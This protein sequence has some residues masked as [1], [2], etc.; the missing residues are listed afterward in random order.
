MFAD[1]RQNNGN[2][3]DAFMIKHE[4]GEMVLI[5]ALDWETLN[6]Y[7]LTVQV[8]DG[9]HIVKTQYLNKVIVNVV[10][11]NNHRPEFS[12]STYVV[13]VSENIPIKTELLELKASDR[14]E[15][16]TLLY[17]I[18]SSINPTSGS[19]FHLD[20]VRGILS[21][22]EK[23]DREACHQHV[24][25]VTVKDDGIPTKR[26][27]FARVV[28]NV[29]DHNDHAPR[30]LADNF[31]GHVYETA[32]QGS[33][34]VQVMAVDADKGK[35][36]EIT[37][38]IIS[39]N[40]GGTFS[41]HE[42]LGTIAVVKPL[43]LKSFSEYE[44]AL[45]V[46]AT[47][48]GDPP[49]SSTVPVHVVVT[50][51]DNAPPKIFDDAVVG[52]VCRFDKR[53]Y[54]TEIYENG[55]VGSFVINVHALSRSTVY[56]EMIDGNEMHRLQLNPNS[57]VVT[58]A[59]TIDYELINFLNLTLR[60]TN[61]VHQ[62]AIATLLVHILDANDNA[63][64]FQYTTYTGNV[65]EAAVAATLVMVNNTRPLAVFAR[66]ADSELNALLV[67]EIVDKI[68]NSYFSIDPNTGAIRTVKTLDYEERREFEFE[69]QVSDMGKP[70]LTA[71][72]PA[73]V[74]VYVN[75]VN[76]CSPVFE[77][78]QY[79]ASIL[80]PTFKNVVVTTVRATDADEGS[81]LTYDITGGNSANKFSIDETTGVVTVRD[82]E[83]LS[84]RYAL[85]VRASDGKMFGW[86]R[87]SIAVDKAI[88]SGLIFALDKYVVNITE[89]RAEVEAVAV[90]TVLGN[91]LD[92]HLQFEILNPGP[93]FTIG[94]TSGVIWTK[95]L[96][97]D[98]EVHDSY[99]LIVEARSEL[100]QYRVAQVAVQVNVMDE[101]D[102][103]PLF[104]NLPYFAVV[105]LDARENDVILKVQA[106]DKD[107]GDNGEVRYELTEGDK[108]LFRVNS[109]TGDLALRKQLHE[110]NHELQL[111]VT[112]YDRGM[113]PRHTDVTVIVRVI[114]RSMPLFNQQ[115]YTSAVPE[116]I[117]PYSPV[118]SVQAN[119]PE[120]RKLI[121]SIVEGNSREEFAV[122]F[123]TEF[124]RSVIY[125]VDQLDY[126]VRQSYKLKLQATDAVSGAHAQVL[127]SITVE[128]VNDNAP[129]FSQTSYSVNVLETA[130]PST[131]ILQLA[132][133]DMDSGVNKLVQYTLLTER[134]NASEYFHI[135]PSEAVISIKSPLDREQ[136]S[137]HHFIVVA[138]DSGLP[139]LSSS[140]Q[141]WVTVLDVNDN[142]PRFEQ[143]TYHCFL[144]ELATRGQFVTMVT[145]FDPDLS[146]QTK[147]IYT[148]V[149]GND[150]QCFTINAS[151]G[152]ISL[153]SLHKF[154]QQSAYT[155]N[156]SV[157][158]GVYTS[159]TRV[160]VDILSAN[161]HT[162]HFE[163]SKYQ[164]DFEENQPEDTLVTKLD[165]TDEDR[166]VYGHITYD[167]QSDASKELF[168]I[169]AE[170]GEIYSKVKFD[171]E[172]QQVYEVPVVAVDGGGHSGYT[173]LRVVLSDV[174][175]NA[176]KFRLGEYRANIHANMSVGTTILQVYATD[177]DDGANSMVEY[178]IYE[179]NASETNTT[180]KFAV[181][182]ESGEI[183][184]KRSAL[185][186]ENQVY[187]FFIRARDFGKPSLESEVPVDIFIMGPQDSPPKFPQRA[188]Q[189]FVRENTLV[190]TVITSLDAQTNDTV[191]YSLVSYSGAEEE[192]G[193]IFRIDDE[194]QLIVVGVVDREQRVIHTLT[195]RAQTES[196]PPLTAFTDITIQVMDENDN[197]PVFESNPY[198]V[199]VAENMAEGSTVLKVVAH[200]RDLGYSAGIR[201][202]LDPASENV[203]NVFAIDAATG[204]ITTLVPLD[205]EAKGRYSFGVVAK[206]N[207]SPVRSA[208]T[209][210]HVEVEDYN[211]NPPRFTQDVYRAAVNEDA[212]IGTVVITV[213]TTDDD[214]NL[215]S[216][217]EYYLTAGDS[218]GH[219]QIQHT[220]EISVQKELDRESTASY[221]LEVTATDGTFV[222]TTL[223][224]V[225]ILDAND[226]PPVC[227]KVKYT[228]RVSENVSVGSLILSIEATDRDEAHNA[229][230]LYSVSGFGSSDFAADSSTGLLKVSK[231]LDRETQSRYQLTAHVKDSDY[232]HWECTSEVEIFL[233]DIND[234]PPEFTQDIY[235]V[236]VPED[237]EIRTLIGKVHATDRDLGVNRKVK[238]SFVDS[239]GGHF[240]IDNYSGL[241]TLA[242]PLDREQRALFNLTVKA[243]DQGVP[244]LSSLAHLLVIVLDINDNPPEFASR[245]YHASIT[246]SASPG[247]DVVRV[248]A[249]SRDS[250]I[251]A[252]ITY[253]I[254]AGNEH[255]KFAIHPKTGVVTVV[256]AL[257]YEKARDYYLTVQANDGGIPS[258]SNH[259]TVNITVLDA[260]DN[261]PLFAQSSYSSIV[262]EDAPV[263]HRVLQVVATDLDSFANS[264]I[265]YFIIKGDPHGHFHVDKQNGHISVQ[266]PLD[267][268]TI[269]SYKIEIQSQDDGVP[270]LSDTVIVNIEVTDANDNPPVFSLTNYSAAVQEDKPP[271]YVVLTFS[272]SDSDIPANGP[273]F[274]YKIVAGNDDHEFS[275]GPDG[276]LRT[277]SG[278]NHTIRDHY[279]LRIQVSDNGTPSLHSYAWA[280]IVIIEESRF[281][282]IITPLEVT[283]SSYLDEF[284]G[285][286]LGRIK[287][288]DSDP[289]DELAFSLGPG[290][291]HLFEINP[292]DGTLAALAGLDAGTYQLNITVSDGKF[293]SSALS[294]VVVHAVT[295]QMLEHALVIR[296]EGVT[297]EAFIVSYQ[298]NFVKAVQNYLPVRSNDVLILSMQPAPHMSR[299]RRNIHQDLDVMFAV[300]RGEKGFYPRENVRK[301]LRDGK[302]KLEMIT[303]LKIVKI[304]DNLCTPDR[305]VRGE[306]RDHLVM[307]ELMVIGVTTDS[308]SFVSPQHHHR[309]ECR[310]QE[311]FGGDMCDKIINECAKNPCPKNALCVADSSPKGYS[312][313]C[314]KGK[315][316]PGCDD[317]DN[318]VDPF[319]YKEKKPITFHGK[320]YARYT[321]V[322]PMDKRFS[323]KFYV[324]TSQPTGC[325]KYAAG[326]VDYSI[327]EIV[328]GV[329]QYR[330][331]CGSGEGIVRVE[332][333][334]INDRKWHEIKL[335]RHGNKAELIVDGKS[336]SRGST[337]GL[338]DVLNIESNEMY[339]G[340]EVH[341]H[342]TIPGYDDVRLGFVGCL[343]HISI[344]RVTLPLFVSNGNSVATLSRVM[345]VD[346]QCSLSGDLG[347]CGTQ[348][349]VNGGTC[350][351]SDGDGDGDGD[352]GAN[353]VCHC[354]TR[355]VGERCQ[356]DTNP[357]ASNPCLYGGTCSNLK[358]D[359][360]CACP[361]KLSGKR[362]DYGRYCNPN[363]CQHN[364]VCEE[365]SHGPMC[366][367][368]GFQGEFCDID[369]D[370]CALNPCLNGG[371][372]LNTVGSFVCECGPNA[373]GALCDNLMVASGSITSSSMNITIE[374]IIGIVA[375]VLILII[376][377]L[378]FVAV[379]KLRAKRAA[380]RRLELLRD[381][382][383]DV[384]LKNKTHDDLKRNSKLSNLEA[385][386]TLMLPPRPASYTP[387]RHDSITALNNFDTVRSYGSAADDL[388]NIPKYNTD[389][390]QNITKNNTAALPTSL[391]N[392]TPE[393]ESLH[394][395]AWDLDHN[396]KESYPDNKIHNVDLKTTRGPVHNPA[397]SHHH[398]LKNKSLSTFD[399]VLRDNSAMG[400][401]N[402]PLV[403][404]TPAG[405][406]CA[407]GLELIHA[408]SRPLAASPQA[409]NKG[410][411]WDCSDW[412]RS[413]N[414]LPNI[415]EVPTNEVPDSPSLHS[416]ESNSR[417]DNAS[418]TPPADLDSEYVGDSEYNEYDSDDNRHAPLTH[419]SFDELLSLSDVDFADDP[420]DTKRNYKPLHPDQYLPTYSIATDTEEDEPTPYLPHMRT[421]TH[422]LRSAAAATAATL[423]AM[424][425]SLGGYTS[426]NASCSDL[427]DN[428]CEIED[429]ELCSETD[430]DERRTSY[431]T[432]V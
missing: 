136:F 416:N 37:Y 137:R 406:A 190:G 376:L 117:Q 422:G 358:N 4:T 188:N 119:S 70:R 388:E 161:L 423:D 217:V 32:A 407:A 343:D 83:N 405:H 44:Y 346:F 369:V 387:S 401:E 332:H 55:N 344:D 156:V 236:T 172:K 14:D 51:A 234:N 39:G 49:L 67:Y 126:E 403:E 18:H 133:K 298:R 101:N 384:I 180:D 146:D 20:P 84:D 181:N 364:G 182:R 252:E 396:L 338:N 171:R 149:G 318:C 420:D 102:N 366:K 154:S 22:A 409:N 75:D 53:E 177:D 398:P 370:E 255:G 93:M 110:M 28:I 91:S 65:S 283:V 257:D 90:L 199:S 254:V 105:P 303:E 280:N 25:T 426:T 379:R 89:N 307:D 220:G 258:L 250:G 397:A 381:P 226:N 247:S 415:T 42:T 374:E 267:R 193:G 170:T 63:P 52:F 157:S 115:Y 145:A 363:P 264:R 353:F 253:S 417:V 160:K 421:N 239:A 412:A 13:A 153:M 124:D 148:I 350:K 410:Y 100:E 46:K 178:S 361:D 120:G 132:T 367:C 279:L 326:R 271:G 192:S 355:F 265:S 380:Q 57:G 206:D 30:F 131:G 97:F 393:S 230:L 88:R 241:V 289:Y 47:D 259:A 261:Y 159:S 168:G 5:K 324:R 214:Q 59:R 310:C 431:S 196:S 85:T 231:P 114:S 106:I 320:S 164:V 43:K 411:H 352:G 256:Q 21:V 195:V 58:V 147:L 365:G 77:Q 325:L 244:Q 87:V 211:D 359:F 96:P 99:T 36:A 12:E 69:V 225:E 142:P 128:D 233:S 92:E 98:R 66:D 221:R 278:F 378:L 377:V 290:Y 304:Y 419:P 284:P 394:K 10:D 418:A 113:E 82:R 354:H 6:K 408:L 333:V 7:N 56:Y 424:S 340:A 215:N 351:P 287:A 390:L 246:E 232:S 15:N 17:Y 395:P 372:C 311:G 299:S 184:L 150:Q 61:M 135:E 9:V 8:T 76:D 342:P 295:D 356:V 80:M 186:L 391:P 191:F 383:K 24:L 207:G 357:C 266:S 235:S 269:A 274:T 48:R 197:D 129:E 428:L 288:I 348:P 107:I 176:P 275:I 322:N 103:A 360:H 330:F 127:V 140:T 141:V 95:G 179:T 205:R 300:R 402:L 262:R 216:R 282:P 314:Q 240:A 335:D 273:P 35:N 317:D 327:L 112:A 294:T 194:G 202:S 328:N 432:R 286:V 166:G 1:V 430:T 111:V 427:S 189:F 223:I 38:A 143:P 385:P 263:G 315:F 218:F 347:A 368:R 62:T 237:T 173:L 308:L 371:R 382:P 198:R 242:K 151:T 187:Q 238:Y 331:N 78:Q 414:P 245:I 251:N 285:G 319:C 169:N 248:L 116:S 118:L 281:R 2:V 167:I 121:Y 81:R 270:N 34:V 23:L 373:T 389:F 94:A 309:V 349:C 200:D 125:V 429:S 399:P 425:M 29:Q 229:R 72:M 212:L 41:I 329:V 27:N 130:P 134:G 139:S 345:N 341:P 272:V 162:P 243:T 224:N 138:T 64:R 50:M 155:L 165:A 122:D 334:H 71:P 292:R 73:K 163:K 3:D 175:D 222:T 219:F 400:R 16:P 316:A 413:Q 301:I 313:Q 144:S 339:F 302:S 201:Y 268:E 11:L 362:C 79:N 276:I 68:A 293:S 213:S 323:L 392:Q 305:C 109:K 203:H 183:Y 404:D 123:N 33:S 60:A 209:T 108:E 19:K 291:Q 249:T 277:N 31:L 337:P 152:V 158:D 210:V 296:F 306:C 297:P 228:E 86:T 185:S 375:T 26:S 40:I 321:L 260:N 227:K 208:V 312:C 45:V 174:N 336:S 74:T 386:H 104:I 204:W 54:S